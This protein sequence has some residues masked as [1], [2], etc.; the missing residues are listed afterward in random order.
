MTAL[1]PATLIF[2]TTLATAVSAASLEVTIQNVQSEQGILML[3]V[4]D[5]AGYRTTPVRATAQAAT[6]S[7]FRFEDLAEGDYAVAVFH[8]KNGNGKLDVN[9]MGV[10]TEPYGF[11]LHAPAGMGAPVWADAMFNLPA[12]GT[13]ISVPLSN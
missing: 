2:A 8:D 10:P 5:S 4:Y 9:L 12:S 3:A 7:V 1:H 11:S 13:R 6:A